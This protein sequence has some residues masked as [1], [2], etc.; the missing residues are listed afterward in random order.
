[1]HMNHAGIGM[2]SAGS[3]TSTPGRPG[4]VKRALVRFGAVAIAT[5]ATLSVAAPASAAPTTYL[6]A[7]GDVTGLAQKSGTPMAK[8]MYSLFGRR[9]PT[10]SDMITVKAARVPWAQVAAAQPGS[11][12]YNQIATYARGV[13]AL[14]RRVMVAYHHEPEAK[15]SDS[16]GSSAQF[17][18]AW[19]KVVNIFEAQGAT[20]VEWTWQMTAFSFRV[21]AT[22]DRAAIKW[23]PGD[24]YVD[25]V[26]ADGYNWGRC[27]GHGGAWLS[28]ASFMD[29]VVRFA[30]AHGK[31]ASLGEFGAP[32]DSRRAQW[33]RDSGRYLA[34]NRDVINAAFYFQNG[35]TG[36]TC[37][38]QLKTA[39]EFDA[40]GDIARN[41]SVFRS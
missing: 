9:V 41:T 29:P 34:A 36:S 8:H 39:A 7:A 22:D 14:N 31:K 37:S 23:Y 13:K 5:V 2:P 30:R 26:S 6:G 12:L 38:W 21:K 11:A 32:A 19:R 10:D 15:H 25:N 3:R 33:L 35:G 20:N 4:L 18:A 40:Y 1:M 16:Y 27:Y 24:A 17:I 28:M